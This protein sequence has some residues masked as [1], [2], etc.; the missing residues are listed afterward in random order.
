VGN[1]FG[2]PGLKNRNNN[3]AILRIRCIAILILRERENLSR[4][5]AIKRHHAD[6]YAEAAGDHHADADKIAVKSIEDERQLS[7]RPIPPVNVITVINL[8]IVLAASVPCDHVFTQREK[9]PAAVRSRTRA[10]RLI[11]MFGPRN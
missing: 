2:Y 7:S 5:S 1:Y 4:L 10:I 8:T 3:G 6:R 9:W 11:D